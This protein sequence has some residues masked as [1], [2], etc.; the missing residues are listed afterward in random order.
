MKFFEQKIKGVFII[1]AESVIDDRGIFRRQF[2][3]KEFADHGIA[4]NISQANISENHHALTLR[5]FHY[6]DHPFAEAKTLSCLR[7]K[8]YDVIVD[9][10]EE[11][12]TYMEW[13]SVEISGDNRKC[14][15]IPIGCA[16]AFLTLEKNCMINYYISQSYEPSAEKGIRYND[17][18]FDFKF[19]AEPI[20]ISDR[21][22][23]H[24]D[25]I[26]K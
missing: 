11:S 13:I 22:L 24:P 8:L 1:E 25:F 23:N 4:N 20:I 21:D 16:N 7:G 2:C 26:K 19:P 9:L 15:H 12:I 17:P 18:S 10:R 6:Q 3:E 14:L 5:G